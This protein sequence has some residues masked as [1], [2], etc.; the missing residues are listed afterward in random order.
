MKKIDG[1]IRVKDFQKIPLIDNYIDHT[2]V[3]YPFISKGNGENHDILFG[4]ILTNKGKWQSLS[5]LLSKSKCTT[6]ITKIYTYRDL[7][8]NI[9]DFDINNFDNFDNPVSNQPLN[10]NFVIHKQICYADIQGNY[11][12]TISKN[13]LLDS[14]SFPK[15]N[16]YH[17][18]HER[19]AKTYKFGTVNL[20]LVTTIK[21]NKD[22]NH[23]EITFQYKKN[24]SDTIS[25]DLEY[26]KGVLNK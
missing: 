21:N 25:R 22:Y 26:V 1:F 23:I 3:I 17:D 10:K 16:T 4:S 2:F 13:N 18:E 8:Y 9:N 6:N 14:D 7:E 20:N 11:L 24:M 5:K 15:L 12:L 19:I